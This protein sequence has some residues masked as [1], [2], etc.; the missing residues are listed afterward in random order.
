MLDNKHSLAEFDKFQKK[1][2]KHWITNGPDLNS[3]SEAEQFG[4]YIALKLKKVKIP[5][6]KN[7]VD[8]SVSTSQIRQVF[9]KLKS[10]EAKGGIK[11]EAEKIEFLMLKPLMAYVVGRHKKTG[12]KQL[13]VRL[14]WGIDE[15]MEAD[16]DDERQK[17]FKNFC[18]L[19]EAILAY[20]KSH[21][22]N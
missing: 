5:N 16:D 20:H 1:T 9:T 19:F 12:L 14:N 2:I 21:G 17:R 22:G 3:V 11:N 18:K 13:Q 7:S 10:I 4:K 6:K 8:E 15:V